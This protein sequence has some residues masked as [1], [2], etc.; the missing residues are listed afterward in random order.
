MPYRHHEQ[1]NALKNMIKRIVV[2]VHGMN[3]DL[4]L[5]RNGS[6]KHGGDANKSYQELGLISSAICKQKR[7]P[8]ENQ[9][10]DIIQNGHPEVS[11]DKKHQDAI[12]HEDRQRTAVDMR[13]CRTR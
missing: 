13:G 5:L 11:S 2:E 8:K 6:K 9:G 3:P 1:C 12:C 7:Y 10:R 4:R